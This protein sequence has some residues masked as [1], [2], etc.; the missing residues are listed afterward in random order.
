MV[1]TVGSENRLRSPAELQAFSESA[2]TEPGGTFFFNCEIV[3]SS[4]RSYNS[5]ADKLRL[6]PNDSN[7]NWSRNPSDCRPGERPAL[8]FGSAV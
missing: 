4:A 5:P 2:G 7:D 6:C 3:I 8:S 1:E